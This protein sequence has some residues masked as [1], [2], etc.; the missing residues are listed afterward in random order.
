MFFT[1][2][3]KTIFLSLGMIMG[4]FSL[5]VNNINQV[6]IQS[7][8]NADLVFESKKLQKKLDNLSGIQETTTNKEIEQFVS[9]KKIETV[10]NGYDA[11]QSDI[12]ILVNID[13]QN[14]KNTDSK[15]NS[16]VLITR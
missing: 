15:S 4:L 14:Q 9:K 3:I 8:V 13:R 7:S 5:L 10:F 2:E 1:R 16:P 11:K 6:N 12:D